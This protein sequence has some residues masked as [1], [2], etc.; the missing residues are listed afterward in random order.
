[1]KKFI[2]FWVLVLFISCN[3]KRQVERAFY[4][5][6]NDAGYDIDFEKVNKLDAKK[7]YFKFFEVDYSETVGNFPYSKN[8]PSLGSRVTE[9]SLTVV[10]TIFIK[11]EIY[12]Y[13]TEKDLD[14]LA[15][16]IVFLVDKYFKESFNEKPDINFNEIQI[17]CDW[18]KSTKD[19]YFYLLKQIKTKSKKTVSCTL[20][21]YPYAYPNIMGVPP[22]DKVTLMC[23]NLIKPLEEKSKNAILDTNELEKYLKNKKEY[24][25]HTDI[26]LPIFGWTQLYKNNRFAGLIDI[27]EE[28]VAKFAKKT[29]P[30]WY[31]ITKDTV[32]NYD[33][34]FRKGDQVKCETVTLEQLN[35]TADLLKK[36]LKRKNNITITLFDLNGETFINRKDEE[37][38]AL[39][40][41]FL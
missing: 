12:Q 35:N 27:N 38:E 30:M 7:I 15:D 34:Y 21:L 39:Y 6:R 10:P 23:Y 41:R 32:L 17:D 3:E 26:A 22:V 36:Y 8:R 28:S 19:K 20:R 25:L 5:W 2:F 14:K 24:P 9:D 16:N 13:N 11:N 31:E 1:M 29:E 33:T 40:N 18:T 37:L 4:Y